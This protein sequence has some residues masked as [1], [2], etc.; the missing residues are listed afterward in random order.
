MR[1]EAAR[2]AAGHYGR[3]TEA[4]LTHGQ[5]CGKRHAI[6]GKRAGCAALQPDRTTYFNSTCTLIGMWAFMLGLYRQGLQTGVC[7]HAAVSRS[8][9]PYFQ[10]AALRLNDIAV[11]TTYGQHLSMT[12]AMHVRG[13]WTT[14]GGCNCLGIKLKSS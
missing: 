10:S 6:T 13:F 3:L 7:R 12:L 5:S 4:V 8:D 14:E 9:Q 2:A 1:K 11:D